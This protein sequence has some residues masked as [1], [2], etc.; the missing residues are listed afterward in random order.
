MRKDG[1]RQRL[2]VFSSNVKF[3]RSSENVLHWLRQKGELTHE[4]IVVYWIRNKAS[5]DIFLEEVCFFD[6]KSFTRETSHSTE[7]KMLFLTA[8]TQDNPSQGK[9][10]KIEWNTLKTNWNRWSKDLR[11]LRV[12]IFIE[13]Q[14]Y[15]FLLFKSIYW[16]NKSILKMK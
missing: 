8:P 7:T 4:E 10:R 6:V 13:F 15:L 5:P 2:S 9:I 12:L 1:K 11:C 14:L 3:Y 16:T